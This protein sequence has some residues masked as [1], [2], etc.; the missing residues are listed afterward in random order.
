MLLAYSSNIYALDERKWTPLHYA[1]YNGFPRV[2]KKLLTWSVDLDPKLR[3]ARNSQ[4]KVAFN[5]CKNPETK[6]GFRIIWRAARDGDLDLVRILIRE[7]QDSNEQTQGLKNTPL[8][9]ACMKGHFLIV[10]LLVEL[11]ADRALLN[12]AGKTALIVAEESLDQQLAKENGGRKRA[13]QTRPEKGS[14]LDRLN[15][16]VDFLYEKDGRNR[17]AEQAQ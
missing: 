1:A 5:I 2:C 11:G 12:K 15:A 13:K 9:L 7:G 6:L 3:D 10:R 4:N 17:A 14:L 16:S 8:H